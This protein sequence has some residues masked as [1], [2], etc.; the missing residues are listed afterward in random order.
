MNPPEEQTHADTT[1]GGESLLT[2]VKK[3]L[4]AVY[5]SHIPP[6]LKT[7]V[8][9]TL[10]RLN[11]AMQHSFYQ[12]EY[13]Q[14]TR[15]VE[16]LLSIPW[17]ERSKD[18]LD[19]QKAKEIL[20]KNHFG[21]DHIKERVLEY[22]SVLK[23][24]SQK[25]ESHIISLSR[26]PVLC[27]VG[28]PGTGKTSLGASIAESLG[29]K[30]IRIPMGGMNSPLILRGQTKAYP[31]AEPGMVVKGL[32]RTGIKNP[33]ILLDEIDSIAEGAESDI[34]GVLL[35]LLD[36]EQNS[37]FIDYYIDHPID[38]S[39]VLFICSANKIGN[40]SSAVMDR[41]EIIIM[42][43]YVDEDKIHIAKDYLFPRELENVSLDE[44]IVGITDETWPHIIKPFGYDVDIRALQRTINGI[45]RKV[46]K[47]YIEGK[48][49]QVTITPANLPEFLP[50]FV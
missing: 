26:S 50:E 3:L 35:E 22:L 8:I 43:R 5:N 13:E 41:L 17:N 16:W 20:D 34:M 27:F 25:E 42:P 14:T 30:F 23:L 32:Q 2:E 15:Y 49:Q 48:L 38:L 9:E 36:P 31:E 24:Q 46:A 40:I 6:N 33:V 21:L 1:D 11:R 47:K 39:E 37:T 19:L 18:N 45:L 44:K 10:N 4:D 29:R 7:E 28:L 12:A